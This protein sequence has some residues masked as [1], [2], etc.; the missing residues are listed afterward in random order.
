M[1]WRWGF[2]FYA[3][4]RMFIMLCEAL[5]FDSFGLEFV[6]HLCWF[7]VICVFHVWLLETISCLTSSVL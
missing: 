5:T 1:V 4:L 7:G 3:R 6:F 2:G